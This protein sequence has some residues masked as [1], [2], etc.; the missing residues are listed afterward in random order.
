MVQVHN[1]KFGGSFGEVKERKVRRKSL[2]N[3]LVAVSFVRAS[4]SDGPFLEH[5][6]VTV[7][8]LPEQNDS[9]VEMHPHDSSD[10][11]RSNFH[12]ERGRKLIQQG[13]ERPAQHDPANPEHHCLWG[14]PK[15]PLER[16]NNPYVIKLERI[17]GL[18]VAPEFAKFKKIY[19]LAE[20][21]IDKCGVGPS[22]YANDVGVESSFL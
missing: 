15:T 6:E 10:S 14:R 19:S 13:L 3:E 21:H 18:P 22:G 7:P 12:E 4:E 17:R 20:E 9:Q 2:V 5:D 8:I 11:E 16:S 1:S